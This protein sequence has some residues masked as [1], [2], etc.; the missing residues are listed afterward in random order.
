MIDR[1]SRRLERL[2]ARTDTPGATPPRRVGGAPEGDR[3]A[4]EALYHATGGPTWRQSDNF[5]TD[6]PLSE[7]WGV[8]VYG[9]G[10]V[11]RLE[12]IANALS[13]PIPP[14]LGNLTALESL[15]LGYNGLSG[16][17]PPE[18]ANLTGLQYLQ[19][20]AN[21][22]LC[23]PEDSRLLAWLAAL[24]VQPLPRCTAGG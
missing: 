10:R 9:G 15:R 17:I 4:L 13:G 14:E 19:L 7:W 24:N 2:P 3:A 18:L 21:A 1:L 12:L 6:A 23:A 5:L 16:P 20:Y 22:G 8:T 11:R